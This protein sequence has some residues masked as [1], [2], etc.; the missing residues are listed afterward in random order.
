MIGWQSVEVTHI[1]KCV[2]H[3]ERT[4]NGW[5]EGPG[6][7]VHQVS[8][9]FTRNTW[10]HCFHITTT[11]L[12]I[13]LSKPSIYKYVIQCHINRLYSANI[14]VGIK[15]FMFDSKQNLFYSTSPLPPCS[16]DFFFLQIPYGYFM[17][18]HLNYY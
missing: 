8:D 2:S 4:S 16:I 12:S 10:V 15:M 3:V 13:T 18:L 9:C 14:T 17:R 5:L 6:K 1:P 7:S 11:T